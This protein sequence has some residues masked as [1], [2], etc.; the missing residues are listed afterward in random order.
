MEKEKFICEYCGKEYK[1]KSALK[2]HITKMH[3]SK[4]NETLKKMQSKKQK[5][6][7][8]MI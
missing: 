8:T 2:T 1:T 7:T 4:K 5:N 3:N 6:M